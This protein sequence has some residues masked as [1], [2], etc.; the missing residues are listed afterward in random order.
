MCNNHDPAISMPDEQ[1]CLT[2]NHLGM[3]L[4]D[5][6]ILAQSDRESAMKLFVKDVPPAYLEDANRLLLEQAFDGYIAFLKDR[7]AK[8]EA[9]HVH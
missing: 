3:D 9:I 6:V 1:E 8:Q 2:Q 7:Q 4:A 5:F